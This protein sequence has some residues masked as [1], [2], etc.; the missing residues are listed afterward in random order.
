MRTF[1][2]PAG[3]FRGTVVA[4]V[5]LALIGCATGRR[6]GFP[7]QSLDDTAQI[8]KLEEKFDLAGKLSDYNF[9]SENRS[10]RNQI[11]NQ[12]LVLTDLQYNRFVSDFAFEKQTLDTITDVIVLG[13]SIGSTAVG[14]AGTKTLLSAIASGVT[15]AKLSIDKNF[16]Y[17]KTVSVLVTAMN[18]QRK[19]ALIPIIRGMSQ[20]VEEYPLGQGLADLDAYYRAGTFLGALQAIQADAGAKESRADKELNALR[21]SKFVDDG[22][23]RAIQKFWMPKWTPTGTGDDRFDVDQANQTKLLDWMRT[24]G[25]PDIPIQQFITGADFAERRKQAMQDLNIP[26]FQ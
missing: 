26:P 20:S 5:A 2:A 21:V 16:Y 4:L 10:A 22:S 23:G 1:R 6:P 13:L 17:E 19:T 3:V 9:G 18:A 12:K 24:N 15:G 8:S 11:V 25:L 7:R 14:A